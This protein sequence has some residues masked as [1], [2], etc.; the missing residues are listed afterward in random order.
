VVQHLGEM[1]GLDRVLRGAWN[2][3]TGVSSCGAHVRPRNA[4]SEW[5]DSGVGVCGAAA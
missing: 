3:R 5:Q 4:D 2:E 1:T